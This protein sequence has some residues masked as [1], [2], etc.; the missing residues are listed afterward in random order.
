[1]YLHVS[2]C[3]KAESVSVKAESVSAFVGR[4]QGLSVYLDVFAHIEGWACFCMCQ[5]VSRAERVSARA[6]YACMYEGLSMYS[7]GVGLY[8]GLSAYLH[9]SAHIKG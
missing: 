3:V 2:A 5:H 1:M 4:Y 7:C 9:M 8:Q 6:A